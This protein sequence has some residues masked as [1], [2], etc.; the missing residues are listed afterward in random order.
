[1]ASFHLSVK[2][3]KRSAGRSAT[4]AA[5][6]RH[7]ARITCEREGRVHDYRAKSGVEHSFTVAPDEAPAWAQ[8]REA[9]WNAAEAWENRR[10]SV[11][12]REWELALPAE[13]DGEGRRL[14]VAGFAAELVAR[15]GVAA[16]VA[17]HAPHREGH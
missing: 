4:A 9:L 12:A 10:D 13:L 6:Y 5:P 3:V 1:M 16:D 15:Y 14:L 11:V 7:A 8:D 17:I 2:T